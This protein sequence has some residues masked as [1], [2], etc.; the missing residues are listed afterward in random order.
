MGFFKAEEYVQGQHHATWHSHGNFWR[1]SN[2]GIGLLLKLQ[3]FGEK[4]P[5]IY[6][7]TGYHLFKAKQLTSTNIVRFIKSQR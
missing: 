6:S 4:M 2:A 7:S 5:F 1:Y 3:K